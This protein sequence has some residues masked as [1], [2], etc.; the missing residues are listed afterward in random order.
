MAEI[1]EVIVCPKCKK[2]MKTARGLQIHST[3]VHGRKTFEDEEVAAQRTCDAVQ[4]VD[5]DGEPVAV[6]DI[7]VPDIEDTPIICP[8]SSPVP[9]DPTPVISGVPVGSVIILHGQVYWQNPATFG[10]E[11]VTVDHITV[12]V[13]SS[14]PSGDDVF[15]MCC[16]PG[17]QTLWSVMQSQVLSGQYRI[18]KLA[19]EAP[20]VV[21][22]G[23][24][25]E[26]QVELATFEDFL[27]AFD[28]AT[29]TYNSACAKFEEKKTELFSKM[30][31]FVIKYGE[32]LS[33]DPA[34]IHKVFEL[35]DTKV[36]YSSEDGVYL[37]VDGV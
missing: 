34:K 15:L 37:V 36:C 2:V 4:T 9:T 26:Y 33:D 6:P 22:K 27:D 8:T 5:T 23:S 31:P 21:E 12:N 16:A 32:D 30:G 19:K 10:W 7:L 14:E 18:L 11:L 25:E 35:D 24:A 29:K 13:V 3:R 28:A 17:G 20:K 1:F